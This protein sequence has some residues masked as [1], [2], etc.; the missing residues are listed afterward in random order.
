VKELLESRLSSNKK[1][2]GGGFLIEEAFR[3]SEGLTTSK[4]ERGLEDFIWI[5]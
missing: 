1:G 4:E 2:F 3:L 5:I